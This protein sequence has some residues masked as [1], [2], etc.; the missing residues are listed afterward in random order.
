MLRKSSGNA[1]ALPT[2]RAINLALAFRLPDKRL[3][4]FRFATPK[5]KTRSNARNVRPGFRLS[6]TKPCER[7]CGLQFLQ[8][9]NVLDLDSRTDLE[10][11]FVLAARNGDRQVGSL[12]F[13]IFQIDIVKLF[14]FSATFLIHFCASAGS[15]GSGVF[16]RVSLSLRTVL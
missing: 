6:Q 12:E 1:R 4:A 11:R 15:V 14:L 8:R 16:L 3:L 5:R 13:F 2:V 7:A 9:G 10:G